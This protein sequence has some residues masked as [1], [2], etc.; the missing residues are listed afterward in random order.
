MYNIIIFKKINNS[1]TGQYCY[2]SCL[3]SF[4]M[5][6]LYTVSFLLSTN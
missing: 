2:H 4:M 3:T 1:D 5:K 6:F